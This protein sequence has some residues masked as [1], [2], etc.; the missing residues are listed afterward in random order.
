MEKLSTKELIA[1]VSEYTEINKKQVKL[2]IDAALTQIHATVKSGRAVQLGKLGKFYPADRAARKA[3]SPFSGT[4]VDVPA[5][6][7]MA[8]KRSPAVSNI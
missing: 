1:A 2:V 8:F 4:V 3:N 5:K 7:V 6:R